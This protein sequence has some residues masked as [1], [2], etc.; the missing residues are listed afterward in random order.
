VAVKKSDDI[1]SS[2]FMILNRDLDEKGLKRA[3]GL[4]F[5]NA[6]KDTVYAMNLESNLIHVHD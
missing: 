2:H 5:P 4:F 3:L 6:G 1:R